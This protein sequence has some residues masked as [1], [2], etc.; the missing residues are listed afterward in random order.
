MHTCVRL[1]N[2]LDPPRERTLFRI[3]GIAAD[4]ELSPLL[5]GASARDILFWNRHGREPGRATMDLD[6]CVQVPNWA[7]LAALGDVLRR[8]GF[9]N[10]EEAHAERFLDEETGQQVDILPFGEIAEDGRTVVWP[11]DGSLWNV[12]GL[13]DAFERALRL[14][15]HD[16]GGS[17]RLRL[18][19]VP[20]LVL[21]K[22]VAVHDRPQRRFKRDGTDIAFVMA[23]YLE[24]G[25]TARLRRAPHDGIM[26][27]VDGDLSLAAAVLIGRDI[28]A[29]S[30][31]DTRE[32]VLGL[33]EAEVT[34]ASRCHLARGLQRSLCRG[35]FTRARNHLRCLADGLRWS[36]GG[37]DS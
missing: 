30:S 1:L 18:I 4:R 16:G 27:Q 35:D 15:V 8:H 14:E 21:L 25:N 10:P 33:L 11:Q 37:R 36:V 12:V 19:S 28:G 17:L 22:T 3:A 9:T 5:V 20:A 23:N 7:S 13:R 2:P 29:L 34:S 32:Y 26:Q 6:I 31:R 24:I